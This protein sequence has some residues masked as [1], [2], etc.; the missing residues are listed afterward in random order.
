VFI[1]LNM[2]FRFNL[3]K[4]FYPKDFGI[5]EIWK[6]GTKEYSLED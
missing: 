6:N 2:S 5:L 4:L 1:F 3:D